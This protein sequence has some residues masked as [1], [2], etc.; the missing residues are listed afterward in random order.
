MMDALSQRG[1]VIVIVL[2]YCGA[3]I[4]IECLSSILASDY[5]DFRVILLDNASPDGTFEHIKAWA[6][7]AAPP[8]VSQSPIGAIE[9]AKGPLDFAE[10]RPLD[11]PRDTASLPCLTLVQTG[12]NLGYAGG[13]NVALRWLQSLSDWDYAWILNPDTV[14]A[15]DAMSALAAQMSGRSF[16][17]RRRRAYRLLRPACDHSAMGWC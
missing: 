14:I 2:T 10:R 12:A 13:N 7:G 8:Q 4:A 1:R 11:A 15:S 5:P 17:G 6:R 3:D 16:A 9:N